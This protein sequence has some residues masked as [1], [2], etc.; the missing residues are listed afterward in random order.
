MRLL[1]RNVQLLQISLQILLCGL[2]C[3]KTSRI[4]IGVLARPI[5]PLRA[6]LVALGFLTPFVC[7]LPHTTQAPF[8]ESPVQRNR[9]FSTVHES[10]RAIGR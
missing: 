1:E 9:S 8:P 10:S 2:L 3:V 7:C 4:K 6:N 5:F